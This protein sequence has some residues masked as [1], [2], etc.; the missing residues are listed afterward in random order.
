[1]L[2]RLVRT[3][4]RKVSLLVL[5]MA[6]V[7]AA[8]A[9]TV[10][11]R[12]APAASSHD[13]DVT[14]DLS[15]ASAQPSGTQGHKLDL[16]VPRSHRP[17]P[18]VIF[19]HG[20]G[21]MADNGRMDADKVAAR[22]NPHGFAVAGV[23]VRSSA[24]ARF[25]AQLHDIKGAIRWLRANAEKYHLDPHRFAIMGESSG[26]WATTMTAV[27]GD[28]PKLE[29]T[30]GVRG[31][32]SAV[33][34]AVPFYPP[35][36]FLRM[37]EHMLSDCTPRRGASLPSACHGGPKS[38]ESRLLGCAINDC[39]DKAAAASP[40]TYI[41]KRQVPPF[42]MFHGEQDQL[43]PHHQSRLLFD[44]LASVGKDARF[45]SFPDA[46][47]GTFLQMLSDDDTR[48]GARQETTRDGHTTRPAPA[49]P[50]WQTVVTFLRSALGTGGH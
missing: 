8:V 19:T 38:P 24:Q 13:V 39:P 49:H 33:Q 40:L 34:A 46:R 18:L 47:H 37:D 36:D 29:G 25:P 9:V 50:T 1:M 12:T 4:F 15:Y 21:W 43:V 41:G 44:K 11:A 28:V 22:L 27:T 48:R 42:L 16:Y 2:R 26:G 5:L 7:A 30:V 20:S 31:P 23:A 6:L 14:K 17:L 3:P 10:R 45:F 32:S 35:T